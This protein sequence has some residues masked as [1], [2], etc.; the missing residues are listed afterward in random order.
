MLDRCL[1]SF[2]RVVSLTLTAF[3]VTG[4][5]G[6]GAT[7]QQRVAPQPASPGA[8]NQ[9]SSPQARRAV[10]A[11]TGA[12]RPT[13]APA[14]AGLDVLKGRDS[15]SLGIEVSGGYT[16]ISGV[17]GGRPGA[18]LLNTSWPGLFLINR[19]VVTLDST[20]RVGRET[21][22]GGQTVEVFANRDINPVILRAVR[23]PNVGEAQSADLHSVDNS[24]RP[25][26]LGFLGYGFVKDVAFKLD[27][28]A[29]RLTLYELL[30]SGA[31]IVPA[32]APS[33]VFGV[34]HLGGTREGQMEG[35]VT[36]GGV[37][38]P[39]EI[40]TGAPGALTLTESARHTLESSG[41]LHTTQSG[42]TLAPATIDSVSLTIPVDSIAAGAANHLLIGTRFFAEH[43]TVWNFRTHTLTILRRT[44]GS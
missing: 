19:H 8:V 35:T 18:F 15:T 21:L 30:A 43:P 16:L 41:V 13:A 38:L 11:A 44:S 9:A 34:L 31:T 25:D 14:P 2:A 33:E 1:D 23:Y 42:A 39:A 3:I 7:T 10:S 6:G 26:M 29:R 17:A 5:A 24:R 20:K 4:C 12:R 22:L 37:Q 36:V 40:S 27:Y 28:D 32:M